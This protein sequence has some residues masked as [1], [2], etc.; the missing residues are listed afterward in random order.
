MIFFVYFNF[1]IT[2]RKLDS[3][4]TVPGIV[5]FSTIRKQSG[6]I[7]LPNPLMLAFYN[8]TTP[9]SQPPATLIQILSLKFVFSGMLPN[10]IV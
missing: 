6:F 2:Y 9:T 1:K 4:C 8:H 7:S 5:T 10:G 3:L